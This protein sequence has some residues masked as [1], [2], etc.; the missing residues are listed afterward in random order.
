MYKYSAIHGAAII[1]LV[2]GQRQHHIWNKQVGTFYLL[3]WYTS[4]HLIASRPRP[5]PTKVYPV[6]ASQRTLFSALLSYLGDEHEAPT[7]KE[8]RACHWIATNKPK[9]IENDW[10]KCIMLVQTNRFLHD[11][12]QHSMEDRAMSW[13]SPQSKRMEHDTP[14]TCKDQHPPKLK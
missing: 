14:M 10:S 5:H 9:V 2:E 3:P 11:V 1:I 7:S 6:Q 13:H 12:S 8:Y 4:W